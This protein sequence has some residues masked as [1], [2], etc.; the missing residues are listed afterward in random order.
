LRS[1]AGT[2]GF[3]TTRPALHGLIKTQTVPAKE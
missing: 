3:L 1:G 2:R